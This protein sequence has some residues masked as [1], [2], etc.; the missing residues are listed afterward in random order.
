[1]PD[2]NETL[3][4]Y[5]GH[6]HKCPYLPRRVCQMEFL[7]RGDLPGEV[8]EALLG[9]GFRRSGNMFYRNV[10]PGCAECVQMRIPVASF[11]P[12]GSQKRVVRKNADV[13][14]SIVPAEF[15]TDVFD[16]YQRY[17]AFKHG[18]NGDDKNA[19]RGFLCDSPL[20]TR[21]TLYHAGGVL[22]A[23]GWIDVLPRGLSSV[24]F[25]FEP[26]FARRSPGIFS[27]VREIGIAKSMGLDYYYLGF[28]VEASPKM[29]YKAAFGPHERLI[30]GEW[31]SG[32]VPG[33]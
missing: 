10:C 19:F 9:Q 27:I 1:M 17:C 12:S 32:F 6:T 30:G 33:S 5:R 31:V 18:E 4:L 29:S 14:I 25:A 2:R 20:D 3:V 22:A 24:Y 13:R 15:R 23:V 8:Y 26:E 21:M 7:T 16:L 28:L 11:V